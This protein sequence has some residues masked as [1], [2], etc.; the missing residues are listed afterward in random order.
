MDPQI[1][2]DVYLVQYQR[3]SEQPYSE[4]EVTISIQKANL[5]KLRI[6]WVESNQVQY[7]CIGEIT[8][9]R[10]VVMPP[11]VIVVGK[12]DNHHQHRHIQVIGVEVVVR[13]LA[14]HIWEWNQHERA[15]NEA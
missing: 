14:Y 6:M 3:S 13:V 15:Y 1:S 5:H 7:Q 11:Q 10:D 12:S 2:Q 9:I 8:K 4:W